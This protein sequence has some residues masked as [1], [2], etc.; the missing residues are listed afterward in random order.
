MN[1]IS[2][3][4]STTNRYNHISYI[5]NYHTCRDTFQRSCVKIVLRKFCVP[6]VREKSQS[7]K[8]DNL[9]S[10]YPM[11][12]LKGEEVALDGF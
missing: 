1:N 2:I 8:R 7:Q 10:A 11:K 3:I 9:Q 12:E 6:I 5:H 4:Q